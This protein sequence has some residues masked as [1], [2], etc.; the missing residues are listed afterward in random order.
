[1]DQQTIG[2]IMKEMEQDI[3]CDIYCDL[4]GHER[5]A[6]EIFRLRA[7][8]RRAWNAG[9]RDGYIQGKNDPDFENDEEDEGQA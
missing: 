5:W 1:M 4:Y 2:E 7:E 8:I 9:W 6:E 3:G